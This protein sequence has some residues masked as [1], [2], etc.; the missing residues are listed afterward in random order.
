MLNIKKKLKAIIL[1]L[2]TIEIM[3]KQFEILKDSFF[4]SNLFKN[5]F[6]TYI[7]II[8]ILSYGCIYAFIKNLNQRQKSTK[9]MLYKKKYSKYYDIWRIRQIFI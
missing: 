4:S 6:V 9:C 8:K 7:F 3:K 2:L 1:C 5:Q